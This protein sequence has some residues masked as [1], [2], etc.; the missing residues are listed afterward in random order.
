MI[1]N[2]FEKCGK[3]QKFTLHCHFNTVYKSLSLLLNLKL[4]NPEK[5]I[6]TVQ[7][8]QRACEIINVHTKKIS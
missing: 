1:C 5:S 2:N 3:L 4:H 7:A 8:F 6:P